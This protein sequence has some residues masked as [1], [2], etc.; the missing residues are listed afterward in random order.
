MQE[1]IR[2]KLS[3]EEIQKRINNSLSNKVSSRLTSRNE[4]TKKQKEILSAR[5]PECKKIKQ[6]NIRKTD[7]NY[8]LIKNIE[9]IVN[10]KRPIYLGFGGMGDFVLTLAAYDTRKTDSHIVFF[11][12]DS[13]LEFIKNINK[14]F[15]AS[16]S[17]FSNI[18]GSQLSRDVYKVISSSGCLMPSNHLPN[19]ENICYSDWQNV[20]KYKKTMI[21]NTDWNLKYG[22]NKSLPDS[23]VIGL[24]PSGSWKSQNYR[25]FLAKEEF[26]TIYLKI[27]ESKKTPF[28]FSNISDYKYYCIAN[29]NLTKGFYLTDK[30]IFNFEKK[31][32]TAIDA[33]FFITAVH[34]CEKIIST[35]TWI[36]TY[37]CLINLP[38]TVI[39]NRDYNGKDVKY[40]G[41]SNSDYI[42]LNTDFWPTLKVVG[43]K[44]LI[45]SII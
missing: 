17:I 44:D 18:Y 7:K 6:K 24:T 25:R 13:S 27:L 42:F 3:R 36:K 5:K 39:A 8:D 41:Q 35:D 14:M 15:G 16:L 37:A 43:Y 31:T 23:N 12:N 45:E 28:I 9:F 34:N 26:N 1:P 21:F 38:T 30:E 2:K 11:A 19:N 20:E 29:K 40:G 22:K 4:S 10:K 33:K 32:K